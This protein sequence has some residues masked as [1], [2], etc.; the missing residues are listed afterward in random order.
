MTQKQYHQK[1]VTVNQFFS[2]VNTNQC[3]GVVP[4]DR[5]RLAEQIKTKKSLKMCTQ[6]ENKWLTVAS[7]RNI[8]MIWFSAI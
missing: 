4:I 1:H 6:S 2:T 5:S 8:H 3:T 7:S